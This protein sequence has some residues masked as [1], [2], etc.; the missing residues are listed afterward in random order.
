[1]CFTH[2]NSRFYYEGEKNFTC[3]YQMLF[4][5]GAHR[6]GIGSMLG[7]CG[8]C[9]CTCVPIADTPCGLAA[10]VQDT[11][12]RQGSTTRTSLVGAQSR[13]RST[14]GGRGGA[15]MAMDRLPYSSVN[16]EKLNLIHIGMKKASN[17]RAQLGYQ[18]GLSLTK[19]SRI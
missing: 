11:S 12:H 9:Y 5:L 15:R 18:L 8:C 4:F 1:M 7:C 16:H 3:S 10:F 19:R 13:P 14:M 17:G 2:T 6:G